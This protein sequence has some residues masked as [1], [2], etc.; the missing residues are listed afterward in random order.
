[1]TPIKICERCRAVAISNINVD[2]TDYY[3][4]IRIKYCDNC[5]K[6]IKREQTA[7]RMRELRRRAKEEKKLLKTRVQL[8]EE[9]NTV[10][11]ENIKDYYELLNFMRG[12]IDDE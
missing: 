12:V 6:E 3:S 1:M 2:G 7:R 9:E 4:H 10:L 5:R 8:L 11:R